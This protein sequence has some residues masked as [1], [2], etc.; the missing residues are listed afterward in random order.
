[1]SMAGGERKVNLKGAESENGTKNDSVSVS[2][3]TTSKMWCYEPFHVVN[4]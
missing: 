1:M 4:N 3:G 2:I